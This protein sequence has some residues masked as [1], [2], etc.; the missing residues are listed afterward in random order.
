MLN[1]LCQKAK[2]F[3]RFGS[4]NF[5]EFC[6]LVVIVKELQMIFWTSTDSKSNENMK[7][8]DCKI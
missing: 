3:V 6:Q 1:D 7:E 5:V 8:L 2:H 4:S